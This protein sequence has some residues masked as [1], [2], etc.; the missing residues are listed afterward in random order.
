MLKKEIIYKKSIPFNELQNFITDV[1]TSC[2]IDNVYYP[3]LLDF[4]IRSV[5]LMY[6]SN[7]QFKKNDDGSFDLDDVCKVVY[8]TKY[9]QEILNQSEQ[10]YVLISACKEQIRLNEQ[11]YLTDLSFEKQLQGFIE[12]LDK[13]F[14]NS[15]ETAKNINPDMLE[16]LVNKLGNISDSTIVDAI[17]D[18][19]DKTIEFKPTAKR[20]RKPGTKNNPKE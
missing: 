16:Q 10:L 18:N 5:A 2:T 20:G 9:Y 17:I 19:K 3:S 11:R 14:T 12:K 8:E 4:S 1:V 6:F 13:I 7:Y 15:S